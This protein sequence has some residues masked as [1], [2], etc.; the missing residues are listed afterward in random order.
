[1]TPVLSAQGL[2]VR[3]GGVVALSGVD[4]TVGQGRLVGLIGPNGAGK[5]TFIDAITGFVQP[6]GLVA[7]DGVD[8]SSLSPS[9]RARRGLTRTWQGVELFEDLTV[10]ENVV[11]A[12][13]R[14]HDHRA[15]ES[16]ALLDLD[17]ARDRRVNE[18]PQGER[19]LI[20]LARALAAQPRL[21]ALDE[22]GA[23]LDERQS[24]ALGRLLRRVVERG[25]SLLLVDHDM[26]LVLDTCDEI[27]VLDFGTVIAQGP[28]EQVRT[29]RAVIA[30]YLGTGAA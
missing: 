23:G 8:V 17:H 6:T 25:T 29:D 4:L 30:A 7:L 12:T 9:A 5:T 21:I 1:V 19:R 11:V 13:Q 14:G 24:A 28:P 26:R 27:V 3:F 16:L 10:W 15:E 20:G 18:V 22:P 2:S